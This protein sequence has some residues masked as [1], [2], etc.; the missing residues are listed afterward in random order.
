MSP[1]TGA[2]YAYFLFG[3]KNAR[4]FNE[5][6]IKDFSEV[7]A[8]INAQGQIEVELLGPQSFFPYM[9]NH[10]TTF[11][12]RLDIAEKY[13]DRWTEAGRMVTLGPY[14]LK[15]WEHDK[16]IVMTRSPS[17]YGRPA[18]IKNILAYMIRNLSTALT[19][20]NS[21]QLDFQGQFAFRLVRGV[22]KKAR[23]PSNSPIGGLLL[24]DQCQKASHG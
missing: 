19:L 22:V 11:P 20:V 8:K 9:L 24:W 23:L 12:F 13:G 16:A 10:Q 7:G 14:E 21:G 2:R 15:I 3:I 4:E 6:K 5:G 18:K 17:Y 1:M